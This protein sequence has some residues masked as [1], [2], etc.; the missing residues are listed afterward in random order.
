MASVLL[1]EDDPSL[2]EPL[3]RILEGE[4]HEVILHED[5]GSAV[6]LIKSDM[7][8]DIALVDYWLAEGTSEAALALLH[9]ERPDV[10]V[11]LIT[12]GSKKVSVETTRWLGALDGID[13][14]LQKPFSRRDI[15][16]TF[17]KLGF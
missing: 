15:Q 14:F 17:K 12:G 16:T 11:V 13:E 7:T 10:R 2:S 6:Q 8:V 3:C 9:R 5:A 4:G 1:I